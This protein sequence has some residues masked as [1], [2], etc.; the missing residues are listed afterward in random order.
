[1]IT[2]AAE[3]HHRDAL[4]SALGDRTRA[5]IV[6]M[7]A[8]RP[9]TAT[10]IHRAFRIAAPAVSRH[11]RV[12]REAGLVEER[13]PPEDRRVRL[14]ALR[15]DALAELGAWLD[16]LRGGWQR[17]LESFKGFVALRAERPGGAR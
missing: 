11:L 9:R 8:E 17:Q 10:E 5:D 7:L 14:Y 15:P 2:I 16:E 1:M 3:K 6:E 13:H 12:L 4:L